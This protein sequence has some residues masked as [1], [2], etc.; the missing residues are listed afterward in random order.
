M[1]QGRLRTS[2]RNLPNSDKN[3]NDDD[4]E[5]AAAEQKVTVR[6]TTEAFAIRALPARMCKSSVDRAG[7]NQKLSSRRLTANNVL[8]AS[9]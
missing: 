2:M 8:E 5:E 4:Y 9:P 3:N 6:R 1:R 7:S